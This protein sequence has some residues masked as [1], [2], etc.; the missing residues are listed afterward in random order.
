MVHICSEM[1]APRLT[2]YIRR[3]GSVSAKRDRLIDDDDAE[4]AENILRRRKERD[5]RLSG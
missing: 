4:D 2:G 5:A 3:F 1:E